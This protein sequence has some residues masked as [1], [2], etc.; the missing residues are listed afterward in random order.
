MPKK[1]IE[2]YHFI[3]RFFLYPFCIFAIYL[4]IKMIYGY[5][6]WDNEFIKG[7]QLISGISIIVI[8][9]IYLVLDIII[10]VNDLIK[11]KP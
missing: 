9:S 6:N 10:L 5:Q 8:A 7:K 2:R 3:L 1:F 4:G 11:K